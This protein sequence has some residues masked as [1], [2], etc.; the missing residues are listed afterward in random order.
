MLLLTV[1]ILIGDAGEKGPR[2]L[3]PDT[4]LLLSF[5]ASVGAA[6]VSSRLRRRLAV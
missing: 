1:H 3:V 2:E 5:A 6:A 4:L